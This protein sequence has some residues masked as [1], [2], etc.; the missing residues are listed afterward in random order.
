VGN[1]TD[2]EQVSTSSA[3]APLSGS[4]KGTPTT[5]KHKIVASPV[6]SGELRLATISGIFDL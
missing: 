4:W 5:S 2:A 3:K 6:G 1:S